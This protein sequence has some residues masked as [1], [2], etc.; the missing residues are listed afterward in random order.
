M[1]YVRNLCKSYALYNR[2]VD[3]LKEALNPFR[4][5]YHHTFH[6]LD[7]VSFELERGEVLGI[8]GN[9]GAGKSTLLKMIAGVLTPTAGSVRVEGK[10]ASLL[11]L[12]AGFNPEYTGMENIYFQGTLMGYTRS[13]MGEKI[14]EIVAF[15]DIGEFIHQSVKTYSSGMFARL[16]FA[17]ATSVDPDVLIVD[18]ALSVGDGSFA[19][20]SFDR[21]MHLKE[22]GCTIIFCSHT[23]Y[24]IEMICNR[25]LWLGHGQVMGYGATSEIVKQYEKQTM[26][27][28]TRTHS[29]NSVKKTGAPNGSARIESF[30]VFVDGEETSNTTMQVG[31]SGL[32]TLRI[33]AQWESD[34]TLGVP[35]FAATIHAADGRMIG[36]AGSHI[37]GIQLKQNDTG[38]GDV[39]LSFPHLPL[40]KGEYQV[41][42]YLLCERGILFYDQRIPAARFYVIQPEHN[43]EQGLVHLDRVWG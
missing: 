7:G 20:K 21:I 12:G 39:V 34:V 42:L 36:S 24:Q 37:D 8:I 3:R 35:H 38:K 1:I 18:E 28:E 31:Q 9:N 19:R 14:E 17:V 15:A 5:V 30:G 40:L 2:P 10:V 26:L 33:E 23:L 29:E 4:T 27:D 32:F 22:R 41:E 25:V 16:A 6:A 11:E 13:E 43:T